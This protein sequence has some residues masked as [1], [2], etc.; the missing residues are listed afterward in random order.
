MP[1]VP[2]LSYFIYLYIMQLLLCTSIAKRKFRSHLHNLRKQYI[3]QHQQMIKWKSC[4]LV[5]DLYIS[6]VKNYFLKSKFV[7][8][9]GKIKK[10][11]PFL[12]K[13]V[14]YKLSGGPALYLFQGFGFES[15]LYSYYIIITNV[16]VEYI[17]PLD[18]SFLHL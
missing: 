7:F 14:A 6:S 15:R 11:K 17:M 8:S 5:N 2:K 16:Y 4:R 10:I 1:K 12:M 9:C 3:L 18:F 13:F